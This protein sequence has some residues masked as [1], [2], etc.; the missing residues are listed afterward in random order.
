MSAVSNINGII[1]DKVVVIVRNRFLSNLT[2][3]MLSVL[4]RLNILRLVIHYD[5]FLELYRNLRVISK[6]S[7]V[8]YVS[9]I[10]N[11][12]NVTDDLSF[13][14]V[15][16]RCYRNV[17]LGFIVKHPDEMLEAIN[18]VAIHLLCRRIWLLNEVV[19]VR[20]GGPREAT[21]VKPL[22]LIVPTNE[23]KAL[24]I[25]RSGVFVL[26]R[27]SSH[28]AD[29]GVLKNLFINS[30]RDPSLRSE[31]MITLGVKVRGRLTISEDDIR[32]LE[33]VERY[34]CLKKVA[35]VIG[36]NYI[37]LRKR[38]TDLERELGVKIIV[39]Q[40]GGSEKGSTELTPFGKGLL[41]SV[42]P[43]LDRAKEALLSYG[44]DRYVSFE[45]EVCGEGFIE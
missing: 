17:N 41:S 8:A 25:L 4:R 45:K 3:G 19:A 9:L 29:V 10:T 20:E 5:S 14:K 39:S 7:S 2:E 31:V 6:L 24:G 15:V 43:I 11:L 33:L 1:S 35:E 40:R 21:S 30:K 22:Y 42:K 36:V 44:L 37:V 26:D 34:G 32:V 27:K 12:S 38:L 18:G 16:T 28:P 13:L 23:L